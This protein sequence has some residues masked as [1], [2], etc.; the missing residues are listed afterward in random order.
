MSMVGRHRRGSSAHCFRSRG[1]TSSPRQ[2]EH[3]TQLPVILVSQYI[4]NAQRRYTHTC[5]SVDQFTA[6]P[7]TGTHMNEKPIRVAVNCLPSSFVDYQGLP[8]IS[9]IISRRRNAVFGHIARLDTT[10]PAHTGGL[11]YVGALG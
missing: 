5:T 8:S 1:V 2:L 3:G 7:R 10:V 9:D 6:S 11:K 4:L